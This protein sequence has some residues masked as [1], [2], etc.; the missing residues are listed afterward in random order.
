[1]VGV[2]PV[3]GGQPLL[4]LADMVFQ[5]VDLRFPGIGDDPG[6]AKWR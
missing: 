3:L 6:L 5:P 1:M 4:E 2:L